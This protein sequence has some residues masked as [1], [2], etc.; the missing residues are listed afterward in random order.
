MSHAPRMSIDP[1]PPSS[2]LVARALCRLSPTDRRNLHATRLG[3][4]GA[5]ILSLRP[6][7]VGSTLTIVFHPRGEDRPL[8]PMDAMVIGTRLDPGRPTRCG[9]EV[10][11]PH[12][13][14]RMLD[15][16]ASVVQ[17]L[18]QQDLPTDRRRAQ[19]ERRRHPRIRAE[20]RGRLELPQGPVPF[21]LVN[22]SMGGAL[23]VPQRPLPPNTLPLGG[24]LT[25]TI[26]SPGSQEPLS[27]RARVARHTQQDRHIG[28]GVEFMELDP[29]RANRLEEL[30][31][32]A[33]RVTRAGRSGPP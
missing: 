21:L 11:F 9:F 1:D 22:V 14:D 10:L 3:L 6:P 5:F 7:D 31:M 33:M 27:L 8:P 26:T 2:P 20:L 18:E 30:L 32:N 4:V 16:L 12:L 29:D 23:V 13:D 24:W 25:I 17:A 28:Y 19:P 15:R